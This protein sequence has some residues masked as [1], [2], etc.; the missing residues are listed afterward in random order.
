MPDCTH[1]SFRSE[2]YNLGGP[3]MVYI[4][5][6]AQCNKAI[7]GVPDISKTD[8][9]LSQIKSMVYDIQ[10]KVMYLK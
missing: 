6:C 10:A 4:V 7:G 8:N 5:R 9:E 2:H 3:G 1:H